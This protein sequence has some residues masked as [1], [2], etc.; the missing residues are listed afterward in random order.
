MW[1]AIFGN[2]TAGRVLTCLTGEGPLHA[3]AIA[4]R[5]A[6]ALTPVLNQL[7][8]FQSTGLLESTMVG[9]NRIFRFCPASPLFHPIIEILALKKSELAPPLRDHQSASAT[10]QALPPKEDSPAKT[11]VKPGRKSRPR[12]GR[13]EQAIVEGT[14]F[15]G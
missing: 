3:S 12:S 5:C 2:E 15:L 7:D 4:R 9:R 10:S 14:E 1:K 13:R 11:P 6:L 8:R